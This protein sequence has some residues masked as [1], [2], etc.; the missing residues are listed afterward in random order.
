MEGRA[1]KYAEL[2][3]KKAKIA[4]IKEMISTNQKWA[5]RSLETIHKFQDV[6]EGDQAC[7]LNGVGFNKF[8]APFMCEMADLLKRGIVPSHRQMAA[9]QRVMPKYARQLMEVADN[10][11]RTKALQLVKGLL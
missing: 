6:D 3:T 1:M 2:T 11:A 4:Y 9:I 7:I 8:D 5:L 10:N